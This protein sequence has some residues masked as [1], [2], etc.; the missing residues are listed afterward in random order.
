MNLLTTFSNNAV[1]KA[2]ME[3]GQVLSVC[4]GKFENKF[5]DT[6]NGSVMF[7]SLPSKWLA[8]FTSKDSDAQKKWACKIKLNVHVWSRNI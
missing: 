3:F 7:V 2:F 6:C 8:K 5:K 4:A 1:E